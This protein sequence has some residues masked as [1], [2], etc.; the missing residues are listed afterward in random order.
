MTMQRV[1]TVCA[2]S[3]VLTGNALAQG[4]RAQTDAYLKALDHKSKM[5]A[6][7]HLMRKKGSGQFTTR[8]QNITYSQNKWQPLGPTD[9]A[10]RSQWSQGPSTSRVAGRV[11]AVAYDNRREGVVYAATAHGGVW[12]SEDFGTLW[13]PLSDFNFPTL[14]T[15]AIALDPVNTRIVYVGLGDVHRFGDYNGNPTS[16]I[17]YTN[18]S[19]TGIMKSFNGGVNWVN[20]GRNEMA[21]TAVSAIVVDPVNPKIVIATTGRGVGAPG[22]IWRSED[23]GTSWTNVTPAGV[24]GDWSGIHCFNAY[25]NPRTLPI[26]RPYY[27]TCLGNGVYRS[28]DQGRSWFKINAPLRYQAA[29]QPRGYLLRAISS[30]I[31]PKVVYVMEGN[32]AFS[33]GRFYKGVLKTLSGAP[34]FEWTDITGSYPTNDGVVNNWFRGDYANAISVSSILV[35]TTNQDLLI[36]AHS[37]LAYSVGGNV[38]WTE[39][40]ATMAPGALTHI[41]QH[42]I[43]ANPFNGLQ[44]LLANDGGIYGL[45]FTNGSSVSVSFDGTLNRMLSIASFN[46][47]T[48]NKTNEE[49]LVAGTPTLGVVRHSGTV[50]DS[51]GLAIPPFV[52]P[53]PNIGKTAADPTNFNTQYLGVAGGDIRRSLNRGASFGSIVVQYNPMTDTYNYPFDGTED[54]SLYDAWNAQ[55]PSW[56]QPIYVEP[57]LQQVTVQTV[58]NG[59]VSIATVRPMYTGRTRLWRFDPAPATKVSTTDTDIPSP[60]GQWRQVN[61]TDLGDSGESISAI[62]TTGGGA[63]IYVGTT[64]GKL[65]VTSPVGGNPDSGLDEDPDNGDLIATWRRIDNDSLP[66]RPITSISVTNARPGDILVTLAGTGG[67]HVYRCQDISAQNIL[68]TQQNGLGDDAENIYTRLPDVPVYELVRDPEDPV[69][70]WFVATEVGVFTTIDK[71]STW[72][73]AGTP[74]KLPMVPVTDID[75]ISYVDGGGIAKKFLTAAT[76]GRGAWKFDLSNLEQVRNEPNLSVSFTLGR[77]GAK[78]FAV[79][80]LKNA[81]STTEAPVGPAENVNVVLSN[82]TVGKTVAATETTL[83]IDLTTI[84]VGK[85]KSTSLRYPGT[86][87]PSGSLATFRVDYTYRYNDVTHRKSH[88]VRTRIP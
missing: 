3:L 57:N 14:H 55:G 20:V 50:W 48:F 39:T 8:G 35:G 22:R 43:R 72:T 34:T 71:G 31:D 88:V 41:D 6:A 27:A 13:T 78:I 53:V 74:L 45:N 37:T 9:M 80:N 76:Y 59:P 30:S 66:D 70:T 73:D 2:L 25:N 19:A 46:G 79:V 68:F 63:R 58:P 44:N 4:S 52:P 40:G 36:G 61:T 29:N 16:V 69:N 11:N 23:G 65:W 85:S 49:Q 17:E 38:N 21:G 86:V 60:R 56:Y 75:V 51:S 47:A 67:G 32:S 82:I 81:E 62:T 77:S 10:P 54:G 1:S 5:R 33:D 7:D 42:D 24:N 28:N 84:G 87:G 83:P 64:G 12:K 26:N 18:A 15:S